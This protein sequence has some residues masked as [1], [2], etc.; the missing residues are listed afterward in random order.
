MCLCVCACAAP[1]STKHA[2]QSQRTRSVLA[3]TSINGIPPIMR[4]KT[5][6]QDILALYSDPSETLLETP[7]GAVATISPST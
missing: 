4:L 1:T 6:V 2:D 3:I 7:N 5:T